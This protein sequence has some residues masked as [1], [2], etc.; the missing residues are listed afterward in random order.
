MINI[1]SQL[2]RAYLMQVATEWYDKFY[3]YMTD[4]C[5]VDHE[6]RVIVD[7][8]RKKFSTRYEKLKFQVENEPEYQNFTSFHQNEIEGILHDIVYDKSQFVLADK[9]KIKELA[10]KQDQEWSYAIPI[11]KPYLVT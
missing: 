3:H 7:H 6:F 11:L 9:D 10:K 5:E 8:K 1:S 4:E 2:D